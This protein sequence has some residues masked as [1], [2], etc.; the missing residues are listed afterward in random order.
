M[1]MKMQIRE[2]AELTGVSVRTLHYYDEIGLLKPAIVDSSSGYRY[3]DENSLTKMEEILFY[4]ELDFPLKT[5]KELLSSPDHDRKAAIKQ[6]K[7][8]LK[9]KI[10]RLETLI[11]ALDRAEKGEN[12][13]K[14]FDN[15][16]YE[17]ARRRYEAEAKER[18][19]NTAAYKEYEKKAPGAD[20]TKG[21]EDIMA[22]FAAAMKEG[23]SA[24]SEAALKL[25]EKLQNYISDNF[26]TCTKDILRGLGQMY[27]ADERFKN[28]IDRHAA[29]TAEFISRSIENYCK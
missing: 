7:H 8:L 24:D 5:V 11:D 27:V 28:N 21:L 26:Y 4:R 23:A 1:K 13:M 16:K 2:F 14:A 25:A 15:S 19:G 12:V 22:E 18:W 17:E 9:L 10:E 6:Q 3:Y 29:G 20:A